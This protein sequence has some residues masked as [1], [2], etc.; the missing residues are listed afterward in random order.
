MTRKTA[1]G[2][3]RRRRWRAP[4][5]APTRPG[6]TRRCR[7]PL[8]S[9]SLPRFGECRRARRERAAQRLRQLAVPA[10]EVAH[11]V[12]GL[13]EQRGRVAGV[14]AGQLDRRDRRRVGLIPE[15]DAG[16]QD[17]GAEALVEIDQ[18]RRRLEAERPQ[19][20]A[21]L[22]AA[23]TSRP[24][25]IA[26]VVGL[27]RVASAS[28]KKSTTVRAAGSVR[29]GQEPAR[30]RGVS[31][32]PT[33]ARS[34]AAASRPEA[35]D[36][37]LEAAAQAGAEVL[38]QPGPCRRRCHRVEVQQR[39]HGV[40]PVGD[41]AADLRRAPGRRLSHAATP[42]ESPSTAGPACPTPA[43]PGRRT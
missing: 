31:A 42:R 1:G 30:S 18:R 33:K 25:S 2:A 37:A 6:R 5:A 16:P 22:S 35:R 26:A 7:R 38:L 10:G 19:G 32:S 29:E 34:S 9:P 41:L 13:V 8:H 15:P 17:R 39:V 40:A 20:G 43:P 36:H 23:S 28:P 24:R 21:M 11:L 3:G 4:A 12:P 14:V 27:A